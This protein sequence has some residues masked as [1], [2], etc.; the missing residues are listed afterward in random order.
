VTFVLQLRKSQGKLS[1]RV[2]A[3]HHKQT[4]YNTRTMNST[5][6]RKKTAKQSSAVSLNRENSLYEF[7][8]VRS[9]EVGVTLTALSGGL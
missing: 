9:Y 6:H 7:V 8:A 1:V 4:Q 3:V 5:I 2:A